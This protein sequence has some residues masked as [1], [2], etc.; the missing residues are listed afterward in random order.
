MLKMLAGEEVSPQTEYL[1]RAKDG[2]EIWGLLT[3]TINYD[4]GKP[5]SIAVVAHDITERKRAEEAL[6]ESEKRLQSLNESLEQKVH[7]KTAEVHGLASDLIKATQRERQRISHVLHDDLQQRIYAIQMQLAFLRDGLPIG[8]ELA[9]S[10]VSD[11]EKELSDILKMT[12]DLSI[13]LSPPILRDEGL[14][15]AIDWLANRMRQQYGLPIELQADGSFVIPNEELHVLVFSCVRELLFNVVKHAEASQA[16]VVLQWC[17]GDLRI[18]VR[19]DGLGFALSSPNQQMSGGT[20]VRTGLGLPTIRH[21]LG[22]FGGRIEIQ[23][24]PGA[25][26]RVVL[27]VPV[28]DPV[29]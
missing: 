27:T 6:R 10:E 11:I 23:S 17:D 12:R 15:H 24:E 2:H 19:D 21:Q 26:T 18:E 7:E 25:G 4:Q 20:D 29:D 1:V 3:T 14:A 8:N 22:L 5:R 16:I 28:K 9:A 13:D